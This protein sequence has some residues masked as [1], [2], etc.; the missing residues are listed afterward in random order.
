MAG[1]GPLVLSDPLGIAVVWAQVMWGREGQIGLLICSPTVTTYI[2][3]ASDL[4]L[5]S[6][7][8][9]DPQSEQL[10]H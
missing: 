4:F 3:R 5:V 9:L 10:T 8:P 7:F 1:T 6:P 2:C